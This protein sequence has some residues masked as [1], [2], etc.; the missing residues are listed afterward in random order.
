[1]Q[2]LDA[3]AAAPRL[4]LVTRG[5][6][7]VGA[8]APDL[9][10]AQSPLWGLGRT[11]AIERPELRPTLI[12]LDPA[13]D[14]GAEALVGRAPRRRRRAQV[15]LGAGTVATWPASPAGRGD[16]PPRRG[17]VACAWT[18]PRAVCWTT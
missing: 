1:M 12:D 10:V 6:Q 11:I 14:G 7:P 8:P 9:G 13:D 15:A 5:A 17:S 16:G 18:S 3:S 2:A 4:W